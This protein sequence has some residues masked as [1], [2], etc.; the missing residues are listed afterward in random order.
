MHYSEHEKWVVQNENFKDNDKLKKH[1]GYIHNMKNVNHCREYLYFVW[2]NW[3]HIGDIFKKIF[4]F[5]VN[6][7]KFKSVVT[8][9]WNQVLI[10]V[11]KWNKR[12]FH[13]TTAQTT[14]CIKHVWLNL[15]DNANTNLPMIKYILEWCKKLWKILAV[16]FETT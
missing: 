7:G 1:E 15:I 16:V 4:I 3:I 9:P 13:Y 6:P 10:K 14:N 5:F 8:S 2:S 12:L 11:L